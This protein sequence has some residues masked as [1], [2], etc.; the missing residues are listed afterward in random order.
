MSGYVS[1][2]IGYRTMARMY[3]VEYATDFQQK[4]K[5]HKNKPNTL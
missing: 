2:Y 5:T 4:P 1:Y 3:T